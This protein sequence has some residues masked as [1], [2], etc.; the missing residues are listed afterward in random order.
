LD[1]VDVGRNL[2]IQGGSGKGMSGAAQEKRL[3]AR[4]DGSNHAIGIGT[5]DANCSG[6][7]NGSGRSKTPERR[8]KMV[9]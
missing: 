6:C 9:R 2:V 1:E 3:G 4:V 7:G 8:R 5:L